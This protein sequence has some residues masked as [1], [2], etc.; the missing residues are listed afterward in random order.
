MYSQKPPTRKE[1]GLESD[2]L[3]QNGLPGCHFA[4][5]S[6]YKTKWKKCAHNPKSNSR[7]QNFKCTFSWGTAE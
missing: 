3:F 5:N 6:R 2:F 4:V 7:R 1:S